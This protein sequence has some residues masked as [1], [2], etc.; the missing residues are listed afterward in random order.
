MDVI[1]E[2]IRRA[3]LIYEVLREANYSQFHLLNH[4]CLLGYADADIMGDIVA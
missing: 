3:K 1:E 4:V 2:I